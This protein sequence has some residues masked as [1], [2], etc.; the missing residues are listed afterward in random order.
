MSFI[1]VGSICIVI[2]KSK[3]TFLAVRVDTAWGG[4]VMF[5]ELIFLSIGLATRVTCVRGAML[6]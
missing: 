3:V 4:L 2:L 6:F 5:K 1:D